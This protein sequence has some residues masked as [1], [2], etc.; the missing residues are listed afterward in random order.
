MELHLH[1]FNLQLRHTFRIAHGARTH[2]P[3]LI[4]ELRDG[5]LS[6]FG[7]AT[8]TS[9]YGQSVEKMQETLEQ[10]RSKIESSQWEKAEDFWEIMRPDLETNPFVQ[11]ALDVA[12]HDL[13]A[14]RAGVPLYRHWGLELTELPL[15]NY[16]IGIASVEEMVAKMEETPWPVYKIKLGTDHD[17]EIIRALREHTDAA[18]RVDANCAWTA[19]QTIA[20]APELKALNVEFIEQPL[21]MDDR[22][23][24]ALV[25][26]ESVLPVIADESCQRE[27]DVDRCAGLFHG[28]N[29]KLM[30]CGGLTPARRMIERARSL[31]LR[32]MVGCMTESSVGIAAIA[33]LLPLL[34][35]VDMDG[36]L[37]LKDEP[38]TGVCIENGVVHFVDGPGTGASLR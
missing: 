32:V 6:G 7:E 12:A 2:Q 36:A 4:V 11:C 27:P 26:R 25:H 3:T 30:K 8:A 19:E 28:V 23:G 15:T 29:I 17:L 34:D 10:L 37:L 9:Y 20:L 16:T 35:Y 13:A 14:R 22:A 21:G 24:M 18:F 33:H 5:E 1:P 31:K 38:A